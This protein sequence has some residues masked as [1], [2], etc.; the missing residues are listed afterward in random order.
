MST[1]T[2]WPSTPTPTTRPCSRPARWHALPPQGHR[3]VLVLATD[4]DP[5]S[6]PRSC[7]RDG[8]SARAGSRRRAGRADALGR[9]ARRLPR[10]RRQRAR[11]RAAPDPPGG[12]GSAAPPWRRPP[13]GWPPCSARAGRVLLTYDRNG[14]YGHRDHVR[15]HEVGERAAYLAGTRRVLQATVPRDTI[16]RAVD[17]RPRLPVPAGVRPDVFKRAFSARSEI[18][19]RIDVRR[20]AAAKRA[21]MRAHASQSTAGG[22]APRC[23][24]GRPHPR[25]VPADPPAALRSRVRA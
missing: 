7:R 22:A 4:G 12:R 1:H 17:S 11:A 10:V 25:C 9:G 6:R 14:G 21:S 15:V 19:H 16:V 23:A 24:D 2:S 13:I 5:V 8:G 18:T 3:V 20:Y